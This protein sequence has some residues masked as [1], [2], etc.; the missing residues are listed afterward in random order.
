MLRVVVRRLAPALFAA[1]VVSL[2]SCGT[3]VDGHSSTADGNA[4]LSIQ[5]RVVA[6]D[7]RVNGSVE[8][9]QALEYLTYRAIQDPLT[10]CMAKGGF[11]Y[12]LPPHVD[13]YAG[14]ESLGLPDTFVELAAASVE[15]AR[16]AGFGEAERVRTPM[17][18]PRS[19]AS[20][21]LRKDA[22][23]RLSDL[24][25]VYYNDRLD[26]CLADSDGGHAET[27]PALADELAEE[28]TAVYAAATEDPVVRAATA[29]YASCMRHAGLNFESYYEARDAVVQRL[30]PF[31][32]TL[33]TPDP[34]PQEGPE[35]EAA[36]AFE[37]QVAVAD[38]ECRA[39][40]H[41]LALMRLGPL[42][43]N[44]EIENAAELKQL[45]EDWRRLR[46]RAQR[47]RSADASR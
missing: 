13:I 23:G 2:T 9:R 11:D 3:V 5:E 12:V 26:K 32:L 8:T 36:Q 44:F 33:D 30:N 14:R 15:E 38:A 47:M 39:T 34:L 16:S 45:G 27:R 40:A 7:E 17:V 4:L 24:K 35:W 6:L 28:L 25:E 46:D 1:V 37:I 19:M 42:L 43:E 10:V 22:H 21:Q 31:R 29:G 20:Y 41:R 18:P